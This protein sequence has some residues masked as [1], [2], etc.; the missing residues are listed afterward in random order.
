LR[1][2]WH[3]LQKPRGALSSRRLITSVRNFKFE[4]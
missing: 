2:P 4:V 1:L 3:A